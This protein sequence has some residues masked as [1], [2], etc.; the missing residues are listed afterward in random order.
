MSACCCLPTQATVD[1]PVWRQLLQHC[2]EHGSAEVKASAQQ[3]AASE[4]LDHTL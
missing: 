1:N 3:A 4:G 2:I